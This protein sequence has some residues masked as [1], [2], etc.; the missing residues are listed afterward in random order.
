MT[1]TATLYLFDD[2]KARRW[3]PMTLTRP[4]GELLHGC[5]TIRERSERVLGIPCVGHLSRN[6]LHGFDE[7]GAAPAIQHGEISASGTRVFLCSRAILDFGKVQL[8]E[9]RSRIVVDGQ[10]MGWVVPDGEEPP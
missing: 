10:T 9:R 1:P 4:A 8:P 6:D 5:L 3:A 7:P 2:R